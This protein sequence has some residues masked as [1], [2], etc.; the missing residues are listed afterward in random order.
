[1][2]SYNNSS[3]LCNSQLRTLLIRVKK[4][5]NS[6][7][8]QFSCKHYIY[9]TLENHVQTKYQSLLILQARPSLYRQLRI[10]FIVE[11]TIFTF[12]LFWSFP[13]QQALNEITE[14]VHVVYHTYNK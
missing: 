13:T 1:M 7:P 5:K 9:Y 4:V 12:H 10:N 2:I 11:F 8:N 6:R 3:F 14:R